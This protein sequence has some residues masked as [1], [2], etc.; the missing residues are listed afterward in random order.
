MG[1]WLTTFTYKRQCLILGRVHVN[2]LSL[3]AFIFWFYFLNSPKID[4]Q[5]CLN[6]EQLLILSYMFICLFSC[7]VP[8]RE[9]SEWAKNAKRVVPLNAKYKRL[10]QCSKLRG[11]WLQSKPANRVAE[12]LT[13]ICKWRG[14]LETVTSIRMC[15]ILM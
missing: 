6:S 4:Y 9:L 14:L 11:L 7:E 1:P 15:D 13:E 2:E 8:H 3:G 5:E 10:C 12:N